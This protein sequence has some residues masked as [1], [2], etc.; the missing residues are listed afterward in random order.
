MTPTPAVHPD[1]LACPECGAPMELKPSKFGLFY[2]CTRW[3]NTGCNG[4]HGAHPDGSPLGTPAD[5]KTKDARI[6]AHAAFDTLWKDG[7]MRRKKAYR[8]MQRTLGMTEDEAH[9]GKFSV[10]QCARLL[11]I[12]QSRTTGGER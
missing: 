10:E 4:S 6:A 9:I 11:A 1:I 2:G 3:R 12:I 8:W 7:K 5:R